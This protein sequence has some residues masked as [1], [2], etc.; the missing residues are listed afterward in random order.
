[1]PGLIRRVLLLCGLLICLASLTAHAREVAGVD[2]AEYVDVPGVQ[3]PLLLNGA[4]VRKKLFFK[5]YVVALYLPSRQAEKSGILAGTKARRVLMHI[6]YDE[7]SKE[8]MDKAWQE[9]FE[10]NHDARSMQALQPKL[11]RFKAMF[12][13]LRSGDRVMLDYVPE[14]GTR[15]TIGGEL[16]GVVDGVAFYQ[17]LLRVWLGKEPVNGALKAALLGA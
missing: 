13:T 10:A 12:D 17:A 1:M 14:Q 6:V 11:D 7:I 9:G 8:K 5:I 16:R 3:Q 2:I 15:V 4:G